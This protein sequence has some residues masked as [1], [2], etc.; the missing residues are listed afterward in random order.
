MLEGSYTAIV[1][2]FKT[3]G[4][5]DFSALEALTEYQVENGI[6]GIVAVGTTGESPTVSHEENVDIVKKVVSFSGS[7]TKVIAGTGSNS[8]AEAIFMTEQI[9]DTGASHSLQVSPYYNKPNQEG[10]YRHFSSIADACSIPIILYN[11]PG[12]TGSSIDN[13]TILRL[14]K[15]E[16]IVAV[17]EASGDL[18]KVSDLIQRKPPGFSVISGNDDSAFMLCALGGQGVISVASNVAPALVISMI[19][20]ILENNIEKSRILHHKLSPLFSVLFCD[21]NPIPVKY[22]L[23]IMNLCEEKYRL[24]LCELSNEKKQLVASVLRSLDLV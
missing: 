9:A 19:R 2:P 24:P 14:A 13:D 3:S 12:R 8:T 11:V 16:N 5:I 10:L 4:E 7:R 1:T 20:D 15:H 18:I 23:S 6:D 22:A 21:A 17:K